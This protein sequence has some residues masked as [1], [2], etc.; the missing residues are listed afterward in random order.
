MHFLKLAEKLPKFFST[1][2]VQSITG[3]K[4]ESARVLCTR[5]TKDGIF[6]RIQRDLYC[7]QKVFDR[8]SRADHFHLSGRIQKNTTISFSTALSYYGILPSLPHV[9]EAV[10][11]TRSLQKKG[12][13]HRWDYHKLP[14]KLGFELPKKMGTQGLEFSLASPEKAL[15]DTL[16]LYSLGRYYVDLKKLNLERIDFE[17]LV[18]QAEPFPDRTKKLLENLYGRGKRNM[19]SSL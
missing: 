18:A 5:Y 19:R 14:K 11:F 4:P 15:L 2:D 1:K 16:Y 6:I 3:A 10:S 7:F 8:L 12:G 9:T 17:R 13:E